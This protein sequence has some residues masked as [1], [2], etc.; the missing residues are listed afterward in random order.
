M[1]RELYLVP[2]EACVREADLDLVMTGY[3]MVNGM[4]MTEHARLLSG[5]LKHEWGFQGVALS[6]WHAARTTVATATAGLDL[7]MPGPSGPW[8]GLLIA[9]VRDGRGQRGRGGRQGPADPA[10]GPPGGGPRPE[11]RLAERE[12]PGRHG[13]DRR[14]VLADP[15]LLRRCA[16]AAFTLLRNEARRAAAGSAA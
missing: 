6:D 3:N 13:P 5:I 8:G 7:A 2:F 4:T 16:A 10:A 14:P 11:R 12:C 9:A 1:L 15:A